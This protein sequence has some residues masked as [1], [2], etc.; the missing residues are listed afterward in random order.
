[1]NNS[2]NHYTF[3]VIGEIE[4]LYSALRSQQIHSNSRKRI[5]SKKKACHSKQNYQRLLNAI[6]KNNLKYT[7]GAA[8]KF[9]LEILL[10]YSSG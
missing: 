5:C 3:Y 7:F 1:M 6:Y 4:R 9:N 10:N 8:L 2:I